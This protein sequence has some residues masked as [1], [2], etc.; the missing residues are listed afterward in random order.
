MLL[1]DLGSSGGERVQLLATKKFVGMFS[2]TSTRVE[3]HTVRSLTLSSLKY[4]TNVLDLLTL[5]ILSIAKQGYTLGGLFLVYKA[6]R[7]SIA[8]RLTR[9]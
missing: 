8:E 5:L 1:S 9:D 6:V 3:I 2:G 7:N 4:V